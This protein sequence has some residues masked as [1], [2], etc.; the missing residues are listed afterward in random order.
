MPDKKNP[1]HNSSDLGMKHYL[2][3]VGGSLILSKGMGDLIISM[4]QL[5]DPVQA[6]AAFGAVATLLCFVGTYA[7][8]KGVTRKWHPVKR[9]IAALAFGAATGS[10]LVFLADLDAR[11]IAERAAMPRIDSNT[12]I[13]TRP[14]TI[15]DKHCANKPRG[16]EIEIE[17]EGKR[18]LTM[19]PR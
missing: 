3:V 1:A 12:V 14:F 15:A 13:E 10:G 16:V 8:Q 18:M 19:C 17:H 4:L 11:H 7:A 5:K 2:P 9:G 6:G